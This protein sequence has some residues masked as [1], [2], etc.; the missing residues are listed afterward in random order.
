MIAAKTAKPVNRVWNVHTACRVNEL[1]TKYVLT[2]P[3]HIP[4]IW[5]SQMSGQI[6]VYDHMIQAVSSTEVSAMTIL[7][8]TTLAGVMQHIKQMNVVGWPMII[9]QY[10]GRRSQTPVTTN[11]AT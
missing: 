1:S 9:K 11:D 2:N 3:K 4:T 6:L 5:S 7:K 10:A 8:A